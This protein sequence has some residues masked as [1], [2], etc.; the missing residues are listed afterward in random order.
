[1]FVSFVAAAPSW[2][3]SASPMVSGAAP[4]APAVAAGAA[5]SALSLI[6]LRPFTGPENTRIVLAFSRSTAFVAPDSDRAM[7][8]TITVPG[9]AVA[10]AAEVPAM[11]RV[12]DG[13]VDSVEAA[14]AVE[15]GRFR[16]WFHDS[17]AFRVAGLPAEGDQPFRIVVDARRAGATQATE[18]RLADIARN[19]GRDRVRVVA[20]D[21]GHGGDD[22]GA[23]GPR[24]V[25]VLEK[26]VTLAV[27]RA[28]VDE[29]NRTP[30]LRGELTRSGD[31][32]VPL[33]ERY[34]LA[35]K[36]KADLF[37]SIHANSSRRRGSGSGTEVYFLSQRGASDQADA[38]F[39]NI[40]NAA[41]LVGGV[42]PQSEDGLVNILY[43][44]KRSSALEQSQLL[45]ETVL[46]HVASDRRLESRG[47]KQAGFVVLKSVE[48]PSILVETAFI[49][50]AVEA[51]LLKNPEFQRQMAK[52][53]A[54]GVRGYFARAGVAIGARGD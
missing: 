9:E 48:F 53:I 17:T 42:P 54:E 24:S 41:D 11:L 2:A 6:G 35:E 27:A 38:D 26:N 50:N 1:M 19:K 28:L 32:F 30:G 16:I 33:R 34:H 37:V 39:A 12:R 10:R 22:T 31:Y 3:A 23:H 25:R 51:R 13:V 36:M 29:L 20:V 8:L 44:V 15:G 7:T 43:D 40:E 47:V 49:N 4:A 14:T 18:R 45:A 21:A 46:D 5:S 52:Q